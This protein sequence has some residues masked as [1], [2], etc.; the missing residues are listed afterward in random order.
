[1]RQALLKRGLL[2]KLYLD[3]GPTFRF[4]HLKDITVSP[5]YVPQGRGKVERSFHT[6]RS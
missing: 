1:M 4:H 2:R 3:N 5:F 6:V